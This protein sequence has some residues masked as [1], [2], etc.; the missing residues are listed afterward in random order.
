MN[1][2]LVILLGA[3]CGLIAPV[4]ALPEVIDNSA[5]PPSA[6]PTANNIA[7][8]PSTSSLLEMTGRLE[9]LQT[10]VQQLTGKV[11]EQANTI[12]ELKKQ[13]KARLGDLEDRLQSLETKGS[14][15]ATDATAVP[16]VPADP[17]APPADAPSTGEPAAP[18]PAAPAPETKT[19]VDATPAAA[20]TPAAPAPK[21]AAVSDAES[22]AYKAAYMDLRNGHTDESISA[23]KNYLNTYPSGGL[24]GNAQYWLGE[25]YLVNKDSDAAKQAFN[26]VIEKYPNSPKQADALLMLGKVEMDQNHTDKAREYLN[27]VT[28]QFPNTTAA[29]AATKKLLLL[30]INQ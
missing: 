22:Q 30:N 27:Q 10:E 15:T 13:Q 26:A 23:F 19:P 25:A 11:E 24:S 29:R 12:A 9:Q 5:Y 6:V 28:R 3:Y 17:N 21:A 20:T 2:R 18:V 7:P 16:A 4:Y 8:S 1:K 14:G